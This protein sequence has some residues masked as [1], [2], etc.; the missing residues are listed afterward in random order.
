MCKFLPM[1]FLPH[2]YDVGWLREVCYCGYIMDNGGTAH[3]YDDELIKLGFI[4]KAC[5]LNSPN[6]FSK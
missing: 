6:R 3:L 1:T 2:V 5:L 4:S